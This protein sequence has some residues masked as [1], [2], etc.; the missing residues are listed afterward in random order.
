MK[1]LAAEAKPD[2]GNCR[3]CAYDQADEQKEAGAKEVVQG[4]TNA[5]PNQEPREQVSEDR[6]EGILIF[7]H[8]LESTSIYLGG[9]GRCNLSFK[10]ARTSPPSQAKVNA[11][12]VSPKASRL[13]SSL[14]VNL[15]ITSI[16][17]PSIKIFEK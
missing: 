8:G 12:A 3:A 17:A 2:D 16:I 1:L 10:Y 9:K 5:A 15:E 7:I 13:I 14:L 11:I 4:P 6:P